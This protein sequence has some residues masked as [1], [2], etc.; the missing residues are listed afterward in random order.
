MGDRRLTYLMCQTNC[1]RR[2][3]S[4][5]RQNRLGLSLNLQNA[6]VSFP[7]PVD[8]ISKIIVIVRVGSLTVLY[9]PFVRNTLSFFPIPVFL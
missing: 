5:F 2:L 1:S 6:Y 9:L 3:V 4:T 8:T 7:F